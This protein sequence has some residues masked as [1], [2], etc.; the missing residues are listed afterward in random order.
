LYS[1]SNFDETKE[2]IMK[3][4]LLIGGTEVQPLHNDMSAETDEMKALLSHHPYAPRSVVLGLTEAA[5]HLAVQKDQ[6]VFE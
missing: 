2:D 4:G 3:V 1:T 5:V 6:I